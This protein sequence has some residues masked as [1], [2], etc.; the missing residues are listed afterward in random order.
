MA[1]GLCLLLLLLVVTVPVCHVDAQKG[2]FHPLRDAGVPVDVSSYLQNRPSNCLIEPNKLAQ[3][4]AA[5]QSGSS[6]QFSNQNIGTHSSSNTVTNVGN[7]WGMNSQGGL[8]SL[9]R[10]LPTT[11]SWV[12][13]DSDASQSNSGSRLSAGTWPVY[14]LPPNI[15][16]TKPALT[17]AGSRHAQSSP[18]SYPGQTVIPQA[19]FASAQ[20]HVSSAHSGFGPAHTN[21]IP[22]WS[23]LGYQGGFGTHAVGPHGFPFGHSVGATQGGYGSSPA[24]GL[25]TG[26]SPDQSNLG[27]KHGRPSL[28]QRVV[29]SGLPPAQSAY[30]SFQGTGLQGGLVSVPTH[31]IVYPGQLASSTMPAY[32]QLSTNLLPGY[33]LGSTSVPSNSF[34]LTSA[35]VAGDQSGVATHDIG[36]RAGHG[37]AR[38]TVP[39]VS[40]GPIHFLAPA[41]VAASQVD[42]LP[43]QGSHG[44]RQPVQSQGNFLLGSQGGMASAAHTEQQDDFGLSQ[45][46]YGSMWTPARLL[47]NQV[48]CISKPAVDLTYANP[49]PT[50]GWHPLGSV[51]TR[52]WPV[53]SRS[54]SGQT[55]DVGTYNYQGNLGTPQTSSSYKG[56]YIAGQTPGLLGSAQRTSAKEFKP[57]SSYLWPTLSLSSSSSNPLPVASGAEL[58]WSSSQTGAGFSPSGRN[59]GALGLFQSRGPHVSSGCVPGTSGPS[60][61]A[62]SSG[63][64]GLSRTVLS[65]DALASQGGSL[66]QSS[67]FHSGSAAQGAYGQ[68]ATA[69]SSRL[70]SALGL[71]APQGGFSLDSR[72]TV[73]TVPSTSLGH[74]TD[75]HTIDGPMKFVHSSMPGRVPT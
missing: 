47:T 29:S 10:N 69:S 35:Q 7:S 37:P 50:L 65:Q 34:G 19:G 6:T 39:H 74:A 17:N 26:L 53:S 28:G 4:A 68:S 41:P 45:G 42:L 36:C 11:G 2:S 61:N 54:P 60:P 51:S 23:G 9:Q 33:V 63:N 67:R 30:G 57:A 15:H 14:G 73:K 52:I 62:R 31:G 72:H 38:T 71:S 20:H 18:T 66:A 13:Y 27:S 5:A 32:R 70:A 43:L 75:L 59:L 40:S 8:G 46:G 58:V 21:F 56:G 25:F 1:F 55:G 24:V 12:D 22:V 16:V 64:I 49:S 3:Y 48:D 44:S